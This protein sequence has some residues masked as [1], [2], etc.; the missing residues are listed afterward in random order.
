MKRFLPDVNIWIALT[1]DAHVHHLLAIR[2]YESAKGSGSRIGFNRTTQ[3]GFLRIATNPKAM[4]NDSLSLPAAWRAYDAMLEDSMISYFEE[5]AEVELH[6]R[7]FTGNEACSHKV[8]TDAFLAAFAIAE[9][10]TLV[11]IDRGFARYDGLD[12]VSL[13]Q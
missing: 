3:Q 8:W 13:S 5:S 1:F 2:W 10:L 6:W 7:R 4:G 9:G 11:T 12:L